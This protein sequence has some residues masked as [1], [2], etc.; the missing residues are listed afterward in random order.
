VRQ[1]NILVPN[2]KYYDIFIEENTL[3][4]FQKMFGFNEI[5]KIMSEKLPL[6]KDLFIFFDGI[7]SNNLLSIPWSD[8]KDG[9]VYDKIYGIK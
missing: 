5:K 9:F 6:K 1:Y 2:I 8:L 3:E 7:N 4:N